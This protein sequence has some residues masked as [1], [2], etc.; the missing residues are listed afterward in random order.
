[1][2]YQR[3]NGQFVMHRICKVTQDGYDIIGDA[4]TEIEH[5][6]RPDQIFALITKVKRK[7]KLLSHGDF[8]WEFFEHIWPNLI[9]FRY[10][11]V[12]SYGRL[13]RLLLRKQ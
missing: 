11:L 3:D 8:W 1:M 4:Q 2:F 5:G 7:G 10:L 9:P 12:R 6:V 13:K